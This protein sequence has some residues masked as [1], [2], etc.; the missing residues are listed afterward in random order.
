VFNGRKKTATAK[1]A[2]RTPDKLIGYY[3]KTALITVYD[4]MWFSTDV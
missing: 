4:L 1:Y 2:Q 3:K